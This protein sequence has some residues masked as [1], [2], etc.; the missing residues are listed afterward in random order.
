MRQWDTQYLSFAEPQDI[1]AP[2]VYSNDPSPRVDIQDTDR[3][4]V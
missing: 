1:S 2:A 4:V 3:D